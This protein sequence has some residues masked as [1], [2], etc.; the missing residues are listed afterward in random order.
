M[1]AGTAVIT[2]YARYLYRRYNIYT[3]P[4]H[5]VEFS[6]TSIPVSDPAEQTKRKTAGKRVG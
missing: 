1:H 5:F 2:G 4:G 6:M 3:G